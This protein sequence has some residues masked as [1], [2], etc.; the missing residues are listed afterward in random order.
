[1]LSSHRDGFLYLGNLLSFI[2]SMEES[3][4]WIGWE[5][6]AGVILHGWCQTRLPKHL[7][8]SSWDGRQLNP[9]PS[10]HRTKR[11][12]DE[13]CRIIRKGGV[14][15][16]FLYLL[17]LVYL[18][19]DGNKKVVGRCFLTFSVAAAVFYYF[20]ARNATVVYAVLFNKADYLVNWSKNF[21]SNESLNEEYVKNNS[22]F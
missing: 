22:H 2:N 4:C 3:N 8:C 7:Q 5:K 18:A 21:D 9:K 1:M 15:A 14:I 11:G 20:W 10:F 12:V 13:V 17:S 6:A 19:T 16:M